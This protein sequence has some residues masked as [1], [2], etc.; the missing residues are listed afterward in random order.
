MGELKNKCGVCKVVQSFLTWRVL[1][2]KNQ[3]CDQW[4]WQKNISMG[5]TQPNYHY[6]NSF[7]SQTSIM[8]IREHELPSLVAILRTSCYLL[9]ENVMDKLVFHG[10]KMY[11]YLNRADI[12]VTIKHKEGFT[13]S[14]WILTKYK[15]V[16]S[17]NG[18]PMWISQHDYHKNS[19]G[20]KKY[21]IRKPPYIGK[22][23]HQ[24]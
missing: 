6:I 22:I 12:K 13:N 3:L 1:F 23:K 21:K 19:T 4:N 14:L 20:D 5:D 18:G 2:F 10:D 7:K 17:W 8:T 24:N 11:F 9:T 16:V 15:N